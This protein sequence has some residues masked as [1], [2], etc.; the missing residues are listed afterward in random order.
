M[1]LDALI[2]EYTDA[3]I[4]VGEQLYPT[5]LDAAKHVV[6]T[7]RYP[8]SYSPAGNWEED[9]VI[10]VSHEWIAEKLLRLGHLEHLLLTNTTLRGFKKGLEL[11]FA[12]YVLGQRKRT[13]L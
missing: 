8:P 4:R 1:E 7:R 5:L 3:G 12:D 2:R 11:S 9:S 6:R 10:G 13:A